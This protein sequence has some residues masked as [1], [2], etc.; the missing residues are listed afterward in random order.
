MSSLCKGS[1]RKLGLVL[2]LALLWAASAAM[3]VEEV[4]NPMSG[5][6]IHVEDAAHILSSE[7]IA[8]LEEIA[9]ALDSRTS[10]ELAVVTIDS[11]EGLTV[12]EYAV[13][14]FNR[15]GIGKKDKDNG[16][17]VL[18]SLSDRKA[19]IEVGYGLEGAMTDALS[20]RLIEN[21]GIPNFK[22]GNYPKGLIDL[23]EQVARYVARSQGVELPEFGAVD[24]APP[25]ESPE[26]P[27][28]LLPSA[29]TWGRWWNILVYF[30]FP[31][32][33]LLGLLWKTLRYSR[34][35]ALA[36][37]RIAVD[38]LGNVVVLLFT[39]LLAVG[40][41]ILASGFGSH[42]VRIIAF[43]GVGSSGLLYGIF[44]WLKSSVSSYRLKCPQCGTPMKLRS[45]I[46]EKKFETV[47]EQAE[48]RAQGM[49]YE[50]WDCPSCRRSE[51]LEVKLSGAKNCPQ[52]S[53]RSLVR[54]ST[55]VTSATTAHS[56]L[57]RWKDHC[58]NPKCHYEK[59][60]TTTIPRVSS[61]GSGSSGGSSG[62]GG[63]FGGGS[64][65][66]GGASGSW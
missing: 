5:S 44:R 23:S 51:R 39:G 60:W 28:T 16:V 17:L 14:L 56:G 32:P 24:T 47:E 27:E 48:E 9:K 1:V 18:M 3:K 35:R 53:R 2:S 61:S 19:R 7:Q 63:S 4:P 29:E 58:E 37:R 12:E 10:A 50:F 26:S 25:P 11:L 41:V 62:G 31:G 34:A 46:E 52:C 65:G 55:V 21:Y 66:G 43:T 49:D 59:T 33:A 13:D 20:K 64:S 57:R 54:S 30:M 42:R 22:E 40:G 38:G 45:S 15:F 8:H 36:A 6:G